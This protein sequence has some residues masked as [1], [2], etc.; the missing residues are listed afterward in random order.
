ML[1]VSRQAEGRVLRQLIYKHEPPGV[2]KIERKH[3][4][5]ADDSYIATVEGVDVCSADFEP[6]TAWLFSPYVLQSIDYTMMTSE[7]VVTVE[8]QADEDLNGSLLAQFKQE[9]VW[10]DW[11]IYDIRCDDPPDVE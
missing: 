1:I 7:S 3:R 6:G 9:A 5:D 8:F 10:A 11:I 4:G 2:L